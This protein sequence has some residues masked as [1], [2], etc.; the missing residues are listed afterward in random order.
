MSKTPRFEVINM[1][2][3]FHP[4]MGQA[5]AERTILRKKENGEWENWGDVANRVALGNSLLTKNHH[6]QEAEYKTL[7]KHIAKATIL[8][9]GRHL[10]H[11]D[12]L[13]PERNMEVF[14]NCS[15]ASSS[16]LLFYLLLN[17]SGVGR[18]YD[19]DMMLVNWDYSPTVRCVLDENHGD[20]DWSAHESVR[21]AKHKYGNGR[22]T[23]WH[24]VEDSREGWAKALE[25]WENAAFEKIHK[26][27]M[28]IL[29]FSKVRVKGS[30]IGGMQNRP[31]SGPVPL[32]NAFAKAGTLKGANLDPWHQA[33]YVDHY[34]AECVL[35]GGARRAARMATK[36]WK[37]LNITD[38]CTVK[39]PIEFLGKNISDIKEM[40]ETLAEEGQSP[41]LGFLWSS[42]NSVTVDKEFWRLT[43]LKRNEDEFSTDDAKHARK[44]LKI[45]TEAAYGDGTGEPGVI[46]VDHLVQKDDGWDDLNR[47]DFVGSDKYQI[48]EDTEIFMA[49]LARKAKRKKYHTITNPCGE[50]ALNILGGFC[51]IAD[52]VPYHADTLEEAEESFRVATRALIRVNTMNSVYG[53]EVART[54]RIGVGM[55]GVHE[56][57]WKFFGLGFKDLIDEEKSKEFWEA[58]AR[59]NRAVE[60][61][62]TSYSKKL[63]LNRPHTMTTIK[64]AGCGSL[65]TVI[66]TSTGEK[67]FRD[68]FAEQGLDVTNEEQ[69]KLG[70]WFEIDKPIIVYDKENNEKEVTKFYCNGVQNVYEITMED[71]NSYKFTG[72]HKFLTKEKGWM[73]LDELDGSEDIVTF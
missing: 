15:T 65:D 38:F 20:F 13:Q 12:H 2:R 45:I 27:K 11:G 48:N 58:M 35:V 67:S 34:F 72:N 18:C 60:D 30:P 14:T 9:S 62:A 33:M 51:V 28:L 16:F 7:R 44:V 1:V 22:G 40:R 39:R 49:K 47:G 29:D 56:F 61:E 52:I 32:M 31:A 23:L 70:T 36:F 43:A 68:I 59:F 5:V 3:D 71:N 25:L 66:K 19:N 6:D 46:N 8:M 17:G 55:T 69:F 41:P 4:G 21:D 57:A 63:G 37:D 26:D 10:Q 42:N 50:I 24:E 73:R 64:P 54:N 53:K